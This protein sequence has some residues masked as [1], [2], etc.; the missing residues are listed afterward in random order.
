MQAVIDNDPFGD[1]GAR[2]PS[3]SR[4]KLCLFHIRGQCKHGANCN[5]AHSMV[6]LREAPDLRKTKMC[7][8]LKRGT[9]SAG[10]GCTY[11]HARNE[12]RSTDGVY[13]TQLCRF[14]LSGNCAAGDRCRH[15][16]GVSEMKVM[17]IPFP[18]PKVD[19]HT[20]H[21]LCVSQFLNIPSAQES[22]LKAKDMFNQFAP[23]AE[24]YN[25]G[26]YF[27]G[28]SQFQSQ[29]GKS[30]VG[31]EFQCGTGDSFFEDDEADVLETTDSR[32][33]MSDTR[34]PPSS[35]SGRDF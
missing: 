35:T 3:F 12:L 10:E 28:F 34:A 4:T 30:S 6:E 32:S 23:D 29:M 1:R 15:A 2:C 31:Y 20:D 7:P 26:N 27:A 18:A 21:G 24:N 16:H 19:S 9:C 14:W 13:K 11:A 22:E 8:L 33:V 17:D 25:N 5:Y